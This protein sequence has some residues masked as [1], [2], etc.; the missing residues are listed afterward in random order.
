MT[1]WKAQTP[2]ELVSQM[3]NEILRICNSKMSLTI[4][5]LILTKYLYD[6]LKKE[7]E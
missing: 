1:D 4:P 6:K 5:P 2:E 7:E 3:K